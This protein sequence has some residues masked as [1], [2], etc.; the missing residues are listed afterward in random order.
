M[1]SKNKIK[2]FSGRLQKGGDH[3]IEPR[4]RFQSR[5]GPFELLFRWE[6]NRDEP[7]RAA[8]MRPPLAEAP[9]DGD[10][11]SGSSCGGSFFFFFIAVAVAVAIVFVVP[12]LL[13]RLGTDALPLGVRAR[14][15]PPRGGR[16]GPPRR[17]RD[18]D[19][20]DNDDKVDVRKQSRRR[21]RQRQQQRRRGCDRRLRPLQTLDAVREA[22]AAEP[23]GAR[24]RARRFRCL[25]GPAGSGGEAPEVR[26]GVRRGQCSFLLFFFRL[27][28]DF[29]FRRDPPGSLGAPFTGR[30]ALPGVEDR[31]ARRAR[32]V[33]PHHGT[34][35]LGRRG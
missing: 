34:L 1:T 18:D 2:N 11:E 24:V 23:P 29:D 25:R 28:F 4:P 33:E 15:P 22:D 13:R 14:V 26:V 20:S 30:G 21:R 32:G 6:W 7:L 10:R 3:R 8:A 9:L 17:L 27:F 16:R 31:V 12:F 19:D 35:L 5:L